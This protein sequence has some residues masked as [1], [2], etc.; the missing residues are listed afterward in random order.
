MLHLQLVFTSVDTK[1]GQGIIGVVVV[2][3][4]IVDAT[5][6][7]ILIFLENY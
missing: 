6:F 5:V 1:G 2:D 3:V 7:D 4:I